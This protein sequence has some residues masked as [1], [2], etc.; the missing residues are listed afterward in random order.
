METTMYAK[1]T[2]ILPSTY[3]LNSKIDLKQDKKILFSIQ[4]VFLLT[5]LLFVT[6]ALVF[7]F[8]TKND[9]GVVVNIITSIIIGVV[10]MVLHELTHG[11]MIRFFS[12]KKPHYSFRFPYLCTGSYAYYNKLSFIIITLAPVVL[13]GIV[14]ITLLLVL[15]YKFF[16]SIYI[17]TAINFAGAA[18]DYFQVHTFSK[19]KQSSLIQDNG[20]ETS[21]FDDSI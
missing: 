11:V 12:K 17:V 5:G 2:L 1:N 13:W 21:V 14:L 15:P 8:P 19:L 20:K 10:Y 3:H 7:H 16:L 4:I 9:L 18:G 6:L